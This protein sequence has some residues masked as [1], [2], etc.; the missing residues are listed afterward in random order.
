MFFP[1]YLVTDV[2][3]VILDKKLLKNYVLIL[4]VFLADT[5]KMKK[6]NHNF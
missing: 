1:F 2:A 5:D 4:A 6:K 3:S